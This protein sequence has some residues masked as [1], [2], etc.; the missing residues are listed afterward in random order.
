MLVYKFC[1]VRVVW[2]YMKKGV[3]YP[4]SS[5]VS[6]NEGWGRCVAS[7]EFLKSVL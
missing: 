2:C 5:S 1:V 4:Q 3:K 6:E 7:V